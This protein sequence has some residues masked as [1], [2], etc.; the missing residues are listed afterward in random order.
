MRYAGL[1]TEMSTNLGPNFFS[2][3]WESYIRKGSQA[4]KPTSREDGVTLIQAWVTLIQ[5]R[6]TL[7]QAWVTL[8]EVRVSLTQ[9]WVTLI[10]PWVTLLHAW[11]TLTWS[12]VV[13]LTASNR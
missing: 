7:I 12:Y 3:P 13:W 4:E 9:I 5:V 10:Q 8:T 11:D 1:C 2:L 6:V